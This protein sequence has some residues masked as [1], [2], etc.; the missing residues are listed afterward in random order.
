M[1]SRQVV[2]QMRAEAAL[3][4]FGR[5]LNRIEAQKRL[6]LTYDQGREMAAHQ[7][8]HQRPVTPVSVQGPFTQDELD[9]I[10]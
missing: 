2:L 10:T 4:G 1:G 9:A 8:K 3:S 6:S 7:R 5:V